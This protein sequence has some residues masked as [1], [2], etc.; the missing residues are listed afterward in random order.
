MLQTKL[1]I[2]NIAE[3]KMNSSH[4]NIGDLL[5]VYPETLMTNDPD[6]GAIILGVASNGYLE[7]CLNYLD[8]NN[9]KPEE[10]NILI[11]I[12]KL[13]ANFFK[14]IYTCHILF[15]YKNNNNE[16]LYKNCGYI[17]GKNIG[18][19]INNIKNSFFKNLE[20]ADSL[21]EALTK[22]T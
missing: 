4:L 9:I 7:E 2:V 16:K 5:K 8:W 15:V 14:S 12:K 3:I 21:D 18:N 22:Y 1:N 10:P 11:P 13:K 19:L 17:A 20:T 6:G